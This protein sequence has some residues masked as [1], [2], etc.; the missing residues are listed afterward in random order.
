LL[1]AP[2]LSNYEELKITLANSIMAVVT[3]RE[4]I[5]NA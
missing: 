4:G 2:V 3:L 5:E 1:I